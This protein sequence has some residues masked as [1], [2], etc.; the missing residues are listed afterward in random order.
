VDQTTVY[1]G[2]NSLLETLFPAYKLAIATNKPTDLSIE[3]VKYLGMKEIFEL[4]IG[5][6]VTGKGKPDPAMLVHIASEFG[7]R[8]DEV[9]MVGDSPVDIETARKFGCTA[10]AVAWG[11]NTYEML[12]E[13]RPDFIIH[14][15]M[16]LLD[17]IISPLS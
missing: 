3:I 10:C 17:Y 9:I 7:A 5:P 16:D 14:S 13:A 4:V 8:P 15:P 2:I 11:Y 12:H 6:E 1:P